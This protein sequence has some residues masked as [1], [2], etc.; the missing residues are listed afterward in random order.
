MTPTRSTLHALV[1]GLACLCGCGSSTEGPTATF[2]DLHGATQV[3]RVG[4]PSVSTSLIPPD[5]KDAY[6][7]ATDP[8]R[9]IADFGDDARRALS[10]PDPSVTSCTMD[11][12]CDAGYI[13]GGTV[14]CVNPISLAG[15][16]LVND[17]QAVNLIN[18]AFPDVLSIDLS[19]ATHYAVGSPGG[20]APSDDTITTLLQ[21]IAG[22]LSITPVPDDGVA[23]NDVAL[24]ATFP[25]FAP[26]H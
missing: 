9:D 26:P 11:T 18:V 6:N 25:Y 20:R 10:G 16:T 19:Q 24:P 23:A 15:G 12:D 22:L 3:D 13:C 5:R 8:S 14:G 21:G 7:Q 17:A 1:L 2:T 4:K